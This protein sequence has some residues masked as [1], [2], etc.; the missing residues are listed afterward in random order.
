MRVA[1][2]LAVVVQTGTGVVAAHNVDA[3]DAF[4]CVR[5][6]AVCDEFGKLPKEHSCDYL[7]RESL[8]KRIDEGVC[9]FNIAPEFGVIETRVLLAALAAFGMFGERETFIN[10]CVASGKWKRWVDISKPRNDIDCAELCGHY[11]FSERWFMPIRDKL[12]ANTMYDWLVKDAITRR[13]EELLC[14]SRR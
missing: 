9:S 8:L 5:M 2:W 6:V 11:S 4:E 10:M 12:M 13:L 14:L 1:N 7:L 3:F